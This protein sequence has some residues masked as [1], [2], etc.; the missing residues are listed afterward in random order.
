MYNKRRY[1]NLNIK[2]RQN[3]I[4]S[5]MTAAAAAPILYVYASSWVTLTWD[6]PHTKHANPL[7]S[8]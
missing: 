6:T 2:Q 5:N 4:E 7:D 1:S 3:V 8:I